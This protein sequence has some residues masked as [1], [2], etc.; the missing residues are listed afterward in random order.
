MPGQIETTTQAESVLLIGF[1]K[2]LLSWTA[3]ANFSP[4]CVYF[5]FYLSLVFRYF[6]F[7]W[8]PP[9]TKANTATAGASPCGYE[10]LVKIWIMSIVRLIWLQWRLTTFFLTKR[11]CG[12]WGE[13]DCFGTKFIYGGRAGKCT[14]KMAVTDS[15]DKGKGGK[16]GVKKRE[17]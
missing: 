11:Q 1:S 6:L 3:A 9:P 13:S 17:M 14:F 2:H 15:R 8:F 16:K 5:I 7:I 10:D 12:H 4:N